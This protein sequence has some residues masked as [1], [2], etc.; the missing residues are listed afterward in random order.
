MSVVQGE[1]RGRGGGRGKVRRMGQPVSVDHFEEAL[2]NKY[3]NGMLGFQR[4]Y[5]VSSNRV[6]IPTH[7]NSPPYGNFLT[8]IVYAHS[9]TW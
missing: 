2:H 8:W 7:N 1:K 6:T 4:E 3:R 5:N 9:Y